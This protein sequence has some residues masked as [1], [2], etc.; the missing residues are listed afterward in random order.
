MGMDVDY[1]VAIDSIKELEQ[2]LKKCEHGKREKIADE[3]V[4]FVEKIKKKWKY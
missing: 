2:I 3:I 4:D 1:L